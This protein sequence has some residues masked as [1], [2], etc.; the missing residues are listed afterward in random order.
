MLQRIWHEIDIH[1]I[2]LIGSFNRSA[3]LFLLALAL[4]G[5]ILTGWQLF[6]NFYILNSGHNKEFLGLLTALPSL[7]GL[8]VGLPIGRLSD[9]IG[10]KPSMI[11]GLIASTIFGLAQIS[12]RSE[13]LIAA[14]A[15]AQGVSNMLWAVGQA[16]L[17]TK[18]STKHNRTML[19]S[20]SWGLTTF[21]GFIGSLFAGQL[22][23]AAGDLLGVAHDSAMAYRAV[24]MLSGLM[25]L[26][27]LIPLFL[28]PEPRT[29]PIEETDAPRKPAIAPLPQKPESFWD[30]ARFIAP[31]LGPQ[32]VIGFGA[33][34][35]IPYLNVFFKERYSIS[36]SNLGVLFSLSS[37]MI[38]IGSTVGPRLAVLFRG[39]IPTIVMTQVS[40]LAFLVLMGFAPNLLL[41]S[42]GYLMRTT[43]M[44]MAS[45]LFTAFCMERTPDRNQ[46]LVNSAL[47]MAWSIGWG[48]GP[49]ISGI[50]QERWGFAPL[51]VAT[52]VLYAA[53]SL[54]TWSFF[55]G[56]EPALSGTATAI[57]VNE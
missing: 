17:M 26:T 19:F 40:S 2:Q 9:R 22:P 16:P 48:I 5:M 42:V 49:Y 33:A 30:V 18:I 32:V 27:T 31:M 50:V 38:A 7:A 53:A 23:A 15:V 56:K 36:D 47:S 24:L 46:G 3:R 21:A 44:N 55:H 12:L 6:F 41:S 45:P 14:M 29:A 54:M 28:M 10:R 8:F 37:L 11:I 25:G 43:L 1:Y 52:T 34:I 20:L 39:K 35:L 4:D 57:P 51:F 13:P